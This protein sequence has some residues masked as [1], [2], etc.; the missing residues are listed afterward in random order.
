MISA[1]VVE[2]SPDGGTT[3][4]VLVTIRRLLPSEAPDTNYSHSPLPGGTT[5]HYRVLARNSEG[6]SDW[7][8]TASATTAA[9]NTAPTRTDAWVINRGDTTIV[10][11]NEQ[12]DETNTAQPN[13]FS[14]TVDGHALTLTDVRT[15]RNAIYLT[16]SRFIK[17]GQTV[18]VSY[19][20]PTAG[21]DTNAVQD[22]NGNDAASFSN[23]AVTNESTVEP[24]APGAPGNLA[25]NASSDSQI[26]LSWD[27]PEDNGGRAITGYRIEVSTNGGSRYSDL[28]ADTK[29]TATTYSNTRLLEN[30]TYHYRVSAI[31]SVG[32][33]AASAAASATTGTDVTA[34]TLTEAVVNAAASSIRLEVSEF[35]LKT[36][37]TRPPT[38]AFRVTADGEAVEVTGNEPGP[39]PEWQVHIRRGSIKRGQSV[40]LSYTDPSA[41]ND[42]RA[43]QDLAGNDMESFT[44][45]KVT[46]NSTV[47]PD[48]PEAPRNLSATPVGISRI[49]LQ[50]KAPAYSGGAR[51]TGYRIE[52]STDGGTTFTELEADT[53]NANRAYSDRGLTPG[54]TRHYRVS[55]IN[56]AGTSEPSN[57]ASATA[58]ID[59]DLVQMRV[60]PVRESWPL[61]PEGL[62]P[63][64]RFRLLVVTTNRRN[65]K[66][67]NIRKYNEWVSTQID[68]LGHEAIR[69]FAGQFRA[70]ASATSADSGGHT[71][72]ARD[73]IR[74]KGG[75]RIYWLNGPKVADDGDDFV[76]GS[77]DSDI[78]YKESGEA[79]TSG[80]HTYTGSWS[81]GY[82]QPSSR[83]LGG[84][85]P[86]L[87]NFGPGRTAKI[88]ANE[89][90]P[91]NGVQ[92]RF[93]ALSPVFHVVEENSRANIRISTTRVNATPGDRF[94]Y[95]VQM[96]RPPV[97]PVRILIRRTQHDEQPLPRHNPLSVKP[98]W[99]RFESSFTGVFVNRHGHGMGLERRSSGDAEVSFLGASRLARESVAA[100]LL[101]TP[102][103]EAEHGIRA[104][105]ARGTEGRVCWLRRPAPVGNT[106][107][108]H[109]TVGTLGAA[110]RQFNRRGSQPC[111]GR[112]SMRSLRCCSG[113]GRRRQA[114]YV[115]DDGLG[116][117]QH[118][119]EQRRQVDVALACGAYDAGEDLLGVGALARAVAAANLA[120]DDGGPDGLL[121]APVGGVDGRV[122]QEGEEGAEFG[123]QVRGEALGVVVRRRV[124]DQPADLGEQ[125]A[126][127]GGQAVVADSTGV[128]PVAQREGGLQGVLHLAGPS[129]V[130][131]ILEQLLT[132]S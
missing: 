57:V 12:L 30:R 53:G 110:F 21:D 35:T 49:N 28:V 22:L 132:A 78:G 58:E 72:S 29:S 82:S 80:G 18:R 120:D 36:E 100:A 85:N 127:G 4:S 94:E 63:G 45:F 2:V 88:D 23:V 96:D 108:G 9:D 34:P 60:N 37:E 129:A 10:S 89:V 123:G 116:S 66:D 73:N 126:A 42:D 41:A 83:R 98:I 46:N 7:S 105:A 11:F 5:R 112:A 65:G 17:S 104:S 130:G 117:A 67:K 68:A 25:A 40:R 56:S 97:E 15:F 102:Q 70:L 48:A 90:A 47:E 13:A 6:S 79:H 32:T 109:R 99:L 75:H 24:T 44:D 26:D 14:M 20:D 107:P 125:S 119:G 76:D 122:P 43:L 62:G 113:R 111:V 77:W 3:W 51:I 91:N 115:G 64:S 61:K 1:Y 93:F 86:V 38:S 71:V 31:N 92:Y 106:R 101:P 19:T 114:E 54:R 59:S 118:R 103:P 124:V 69:P 121:G 128:A 131:M 8:S 87:G 81:N 39:G 52:V 27:A 16:G 33:G 84:G 55:A 74:I 50:W 95:T